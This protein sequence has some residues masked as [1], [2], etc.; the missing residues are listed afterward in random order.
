MLGNTE[1]MGIFKC[2]TWVVNEEMV[3]VPGALDGSKCSKCDS[4]WGGIEPFKQ[5]QTAQRDLERY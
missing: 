5:I 3:C 4:L 1:H 2:E